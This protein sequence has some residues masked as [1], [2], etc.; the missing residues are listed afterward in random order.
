MH[1]LDVP[2]EHVEAEGPFLLGRRLSD[3]R[4]A[5]RAGAMTGERAAELEELGIV[6]D[7]EVSSDGVR[8]TGPRSGGPAQ[9]LGGRGRRA[10]R[11]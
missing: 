7:T 2:Y 11:S 8:V 9:R 3:Q 5:Y 10:S 4:R 6:W 1:H